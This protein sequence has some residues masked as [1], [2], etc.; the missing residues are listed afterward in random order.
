M[1]RTIGVPKGEVAVADGPLL[2]PGNYPPPL[3]GKRG[4]KFRIAAVAIAHLAWQEGSTVEGTIELVDAGRV[5]I[6]DVDGV[7]AL[8]PQVEASLLHLLKADTIGLGLQVSLCTL[9]AS[10]RCGHAKHD[11]MALFSIKRQA[12]GLP[13]LFR[14]DR[15]FIVA[16]HEMSAEA[17]PFAPALIDAVNRVVAVDLVLL[18]VDAHVPLLLVA[19]C[20]N[21]D[22]KR[23]VFQGGNTQQGGVA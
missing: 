8:R 10:E 11:G 9:S 21:R 20:L 5:R 4:V 1:Q 2:L 19:V 14:G 17:C 15:A 23:P 3:G 13:F 12:D 22:G 6:V 18:A 16:Q 7:Q